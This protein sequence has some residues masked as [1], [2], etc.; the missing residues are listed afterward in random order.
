MKAQNNIGYACTGRQCKTGNSNKKAFRFIKADNTT[1][2][3]SF[4][5]LE[6]ETNQFANLLKGLGF[7]EGDVFVTFLPKCREQIV[8]FLGSLKN[9]NISGTLFANFGDEAVL[10]RLKD[11]RARG[12][13]TKKN[14]YK[15]LTSV[16]G[17]LTELRYIILIDLDEHLDDRVL[18]YV[19]LLSACGPDFT[20][21]DTEPDT[22]SVLH[23][24]SGST[25]KPKGVLHVHNSLIMQTDTTKKI[26]QLREDDIFWCTAD[27]GWVTGTSY[28][29]IG[30]CSLGVSQIC[31]EGGMNVKKWFEILEQEQ[32]TVWYTAPTALRMIMQESTIDF[33]KYDLSKLRSIFSVGEPLNPEILHWSRTVLKRDIYDTYFQTETGAIMVSNRPG[34]AIKPGSMGVPVDKIK[35][36]IMDD[37]GNM[38]PYNKPG[39]LCIKAPWESMFITYLN[40]Q[41]VYQEKFK[42]GFYYTGDQAYRTEDGYYWFIGRIDDIINTAGHLVS[43]FEVESAILEMEQIIDVAVIAAPDPILFEKVVA[44]VKLKSDLPSTNDLYLQIR[45]YVSKKLSPMCAPAEIII[46]DKIPKNKSGKIMRRYLRALYEGKDPGDISTIDQ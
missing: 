23:Y 39:N 31:Y 1:S 30:P 12:I 2:D 7:Q 20:I 37:E 4:A 41:Q 35:C 14:I 44:Y 6:K 45:L 38:L 27:P 22:P 26:L 36:E 10:D 5:D 46:V 8:A 15:K 25:A 32:V 3:I 24:T 16:W 43:P 17:E 11:A 13:I 19:K 33:N 18:S 29:I 40:K 28:G 9:R 34:Y 42:S 21:P